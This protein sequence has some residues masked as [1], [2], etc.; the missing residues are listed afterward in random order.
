MPGYTSLAVGNRPVGCDGI[1]EVRGSIPLGSTIRPY[2]TRRSVRLIGGLF[3]RARRSR[4]GTPS[5]RSERRRPVAGRALSKARAGRNPKRGVNICIMMQIQRPIRLRTAPTGHP[6]RR[7]MGIASAARR[8]SAAS[9]D[10]SDVKLFVVSFTAFF[11]SF[12]TFLL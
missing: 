10:D 11:I 8:A 4:F 3:F 9:G 6:L 2:G 7:R 1:A 12:Y 5:T